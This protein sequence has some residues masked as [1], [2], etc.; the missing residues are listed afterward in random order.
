MDKTVLFDISE[1]IQALVTSIPS[2]PIFNRIHIQHSKTIEM[3]KLVRYRRKRATQAYEL[4]LSDGKYH[5]AMLAEFKDFLISVK[6]AFDSLAHEVNLIF[7]L[8]IPPRKISFNLYGFV[9]ALEANDSRFSAT[10]ESFCKNGDWFQ[11]FLDLRNP[12]T[13]RGLVEVCAYLKVKVTRDIEIRPA[14]MKKEE[15][16]HDI[17]E[18]SVQR[19]RSIPHLQRD[20]AV[21]EMGFFLPDNPREIDSKKF[22]YKKE[23]VLGEYIKELSKKIDSLFIIC[24]KEAIEELNL[25]KKGIS[26]GHCRYQVCATNCFLRAGN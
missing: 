6:T 3:L 19:L 1:N 10:I 17:S 8:G 24:Y 5:D 12:Q 21:L 20:P 2:C 23:I 16:V 22:V 18:K 11:Y 4:Y 14:F 9:D 7:S 13:H 25:L 26:N 15:E